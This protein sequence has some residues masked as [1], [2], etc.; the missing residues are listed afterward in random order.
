MNF[1]QATEYLF[2]LIDY[3]KTPAQIA[4]QRYLNLDRMLEA[5]AQTGNPQR[6]LRTVHIAGTKGKG[7]TAA[8]TAS[9]LLAA[10]LHVGLY[11]SPHLVTFRERIRIDN[12]MIEEDEFAALV[13]EARPIIEGMRETPLGS[14]TFFETITLL[15]LLAFARRQVDIAVLETGLGGRLDATNVSKPLVTALTTIALDHTVELGD[16]LDLI[17]G[18]KAGIIKPGVPVISAPQ[19]PLAAATIARI[20]QENGSPLYRVGNEILVQSPRSKVQSQQRLQEF[21]V[22]GR[23]GTYEDLQCPL[24]GEHQQVNAAVAIGIAECLQENGL[25]IDAAAMRA[26]IRDVDWPGR[27]Q[28][29][30]ERPLLLLDGAHDP[31]AMTA[32]LAAL[33]RHYPDRPRRY[34]AGFFHEKDWR[35][36]LRQLAPTAE[37]LIL[38]ATDNP[39]AVPAEELAAEAGRLQIPFTVAPNVAAA[40]VDVLARSAPDD[41]ICVTGSLYIVGD[42]LKWWG[43]R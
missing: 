9:I 20:A 22:V 42:A 4:V 3:E 15:A 12:Q 28:V 27:L 34:V 41:L 21:A 32:L 5:L 6:A 24:L 25:P 10:G 38:T 1:Q 31:A 16:T 8:M 33:D 17:A 14:P 18:E 30:Q 11:T 23:L 35:Q 37:E 2:G 26:G 40:V 7:S 39:R 29:L 13:D 19:D 36:M 43:K